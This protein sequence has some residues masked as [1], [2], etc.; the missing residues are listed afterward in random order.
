M[1]PNL[2]KVSANESNVK[3]KSKEC[4]FIGAFVSEAYNNSPKSLR[5]KRQNILS[6]ILNHINSSNQPICCYKYPNTQ[7]HRCSANIPMNVPLIANV[8][9][10]QRCKRCTFD[11]PELAS[12]SEVYPGLFAI[13]ENNAVG[14]VPFIPRHFITAFHA[15]NVQHLRR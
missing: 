9:T 6:L 10:M 5:Q 3:E 11:S 7:R 4:A 12:E 15:E 13:S 8:I 1:K 14:V 2:F